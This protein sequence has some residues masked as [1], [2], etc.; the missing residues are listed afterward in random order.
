MAYDNESNA[1]L[2]N[3]YSR[4]L[5]GRGSAHGRHIANRTVGVGTTVDVTL[6][7]IRA[8]GGDTLRLATT[9]RLDY[10]WDADPATTA[11]EILGGASTEFIEVPRTASV[12]R[13]R[14]PAGAPAAAEISVSRV[15]PEKPQV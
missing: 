3:Q 7:S 8:G 14:V 13:L 12:L 15:N 9:A 5:A 11:H 2:L 6:R 10:C 4:N 1:R